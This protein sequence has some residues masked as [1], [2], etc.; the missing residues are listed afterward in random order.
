MGLNRP[1]FIVDMD[2]RVGSY[3]FGLNMMAP[4][5]APVNWT[6]VTCLG[7]RGETFSRFS[8]IAILH[9]AATRENQC[10]SQDWMLLLIVRGQL[11][12]LTQIS[13]FSVFST[14]AEILQLFPISPTIVYR[15]HIFFILFTYPPL[16]F[17]SYIHP[18]MGWIFYIIWSLF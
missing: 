8:I 7:F 12:R 9:V 5:Q 18:C 15:C 13:V 1:Y 10:L 11:T 6:A 2:Y 4:S 17:T 16:I 3:R 14:D